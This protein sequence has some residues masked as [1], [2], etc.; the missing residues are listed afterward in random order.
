MTMAST[1]KQEQTTHN[2]LPTQI[3]E[4]SNLKSILLSAGWIDVENCQIVPYSVGSSAQTS[5]ETGLRFVDRNSKE[6]H[7]VKVSAIQAYKG[8]F[9]E[10]G[11][12][13]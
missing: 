8:K 12:Q 6:E 1:P 7:I 2:S 13:Y 4:T 5:F 11:S 10:S 9:M 3:V